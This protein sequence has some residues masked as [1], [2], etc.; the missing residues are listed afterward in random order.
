[1]KNGLLESWSRVTSALKSV[2]QIYDRANRVISLGNDVRLRREG[3]RRTVVDGDLVLDAGCG[4]GVMSDVLSKERRCRLVLL[5]ALKPMLIEA[6]RRVE[7]GDY[8]VGVFERMPFRSGTFDAIVCGFSLRDAIDYGEGV[9]EL[10]RVARW[11]G[12]LLIVDIAKP[13]NPMLRAALS[14]YWRF[15]VPFM[16]RAL[17]G[18]VGVSYSELYR[19]YARLPTNGELKDLLESKFE[20]AWMLQRMLGGGVLAIASKGRG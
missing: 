11:G 10:S 13:D 12:R 6:K 16:M 20:K 17:F 1:M 18:R 2:T 19:T 14:I 15:F 5:D 9:G 8:V 4:P 7:G 3:V